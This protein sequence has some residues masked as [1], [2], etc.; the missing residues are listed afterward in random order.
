MFLFP[1]RTWPLVVAL[2]KVLGISS[3]LF[4]KVQ[5][6]LTAEG[7]TFIMGG[8]EDFIVGGVRLRLSNL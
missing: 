7:F 6:L 2:P 5:I 8:W 4:V 1:F 3:F